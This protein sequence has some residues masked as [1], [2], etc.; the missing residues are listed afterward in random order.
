MKKYF[1]SNL[2]SDIRPLEIVTDKEITHVAQYIYVC[3]VD[4]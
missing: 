3:S 4:P 2:K 1:L